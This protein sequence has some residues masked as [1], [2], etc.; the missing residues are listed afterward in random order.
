MQNF[1][2][3]SLGWHQAKSQLIWQEFN[4]DLETPVSCYLKLAGDLKN[5]FLLES[6]EGGASRG[7]YSFIGIN[8]DL[9]WRSFGEVAEICR[10]SPA[11]QNQSSQTQN[12]IKESSPTLESLRKLVASVNLEIPSHLPPMAAG[13]IGYLGYDTIRLIEAIPNQNPDP[14]GLPEGLFMRPTLMLIFDN[15]S[16]RMTL[17]TPIWYDQDQSPSTAW[18]LAQE[19]LGQ[20]RDRLATPLALQKQLA[21]NPN[22]GQE[23]K[24]I[25]LMSA[26]DYQAKV[27]K[28]KEYILAGDIFQVV[29]SQR[30]SAPFIGEEFNFYRALRRTNPAP[31]LFFLQFDGFAI[32]GSSPEILVRNRNKKVTI[33][34]LAGTRKRGAT[35]AEDLRLE[36]EL[37][38][39]PKE[40]AEH[41]ML[42]DLGRNDVGRI[43]KI[44]SVK[45]TSQFQIERYSHVMHIVSNVEGEIREDADSLDALFAGFPA[46]TVSGAPKVRAMEIID[47]LEP[48][49]RG[50]YAGCVGYFAADGSMDSCIALR[51]AVIKDQTIYFQAGAGIVTDSIPEMEQKECEAKAGALFLALQRAFEINRNQ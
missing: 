50:V 34:P 14:L 12:W 32:A 48:F 46:G 37:L 49:K 23:V 24:P 44:G 21:T 11:N 4:G 35:P 43:A 13:L 33:R 39:D 31:F 45:V 26:K 22:D 9:L 18:Q 41:L 30:F 2:E 16:D 40:L 29:L 8:P 51:T 42:L 38:A 10:F 1:E 19:R 15:I 27:E 28:A 3:F 25:A 47:E 7:R 5:A 17:A 20:A 6:V 36:Q